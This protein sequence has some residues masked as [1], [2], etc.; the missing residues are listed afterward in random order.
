MAN[1]LQ[2]RIRLDKPLHRALLLQIGIADEVYK[3]EDRFIALGPG[4]NELQESLEDEGLLMLVNGVGL[5]LSGRPICK[6]AE[7]IRELPLPLGSGPVGRGE[8]V[9]VGARSYF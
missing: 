9:A 6:F 8:L 3:I 1:T 4:R 7:I 2:H 5:L